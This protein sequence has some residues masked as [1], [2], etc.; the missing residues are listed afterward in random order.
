MRG[1]PTCD[2]PSMSP[3]RSL[4]L[5]LSPLQGHVSRPTP[6]WSVYPAH[7]L[8]P[9]T[10][11]EH[12]DGCRRGCWIHEVCLCVDR[13]LRNGGQRGGGSSPNKETL[14]VDGQGRA[15]Q[16]KARERQGRAE[17]GM[18]EQG[19]TSVL[20][21]GKRHPALYLQYPS[22]PQLLR[23][24]SPAIIVES[25]LPEVRSRAS[26]RANE[27]AKR[28][29]KRVSNCAAVLIPIPNCRK[30]FQRQLCQPLKPCTSSFMT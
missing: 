21:K 7:R 14:G 10:S 28:T 12:G 26:E 11:L 13:Q 29:S 4:L 3:Q 8:L 30:G 27:R 23:S 9:F 24:P 25:K 2:P 6:V 5:V 20:R 1:W 18:A 17:Q 19:T 15:G 16:G 22:V